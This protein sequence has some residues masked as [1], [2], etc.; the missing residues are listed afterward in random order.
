M[1]NISNL[2][3]DNNLKLIIDETYK[4]FGNKQS[5]ILYE[6]NGMNILYNFILFQRYID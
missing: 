5:N 6:G 1:E 2:A 4:N 3:R